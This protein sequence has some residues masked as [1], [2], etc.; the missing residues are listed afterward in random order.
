MKT[1]QGGPYYYSH[2]IKLPTRTAILLF[3]SSNEAAYMK[4]YLPFRAIADKRLKCPCNH[5]STITTEGL[6]VCVDVSVNANCVP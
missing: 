5:S 2:V 3:D 4:I 6:D 1:S